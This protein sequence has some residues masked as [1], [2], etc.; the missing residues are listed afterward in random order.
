MTTTTTVPTATHTTDDAGVLLADALSTNA[1]TS[2][3]TG[4]ALALGS[5]WLDGLLGVHAGILAGVGAGLVLFAVGI[6]AALAR[7]AGLDRAARAIIAADIA[8]VAGATV[9]VPL[10]VLTPLGD[11]L[12]VAVSAVVAG[13]AAAQAIGLRRAGSTGRLGV[14]PVEVSGS[15]DIAA[16]PER[17]WAAVAD[18]AGYAAFA[19]GIATTTTDGAVR[20]G[21][22]RRCTDDAGNAWSETCTL[23]EPGRSYRMEVDTETYPLRHRLVLDRFAMTWRVEPIAA[24][25][26]LGLTFSGGAK[27]GVLGRLAMAAMAADAP[28]E[29][30][31]DRYA[32]AL[33]RDAATRGPDDGPHDT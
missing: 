7:P 23:V 2:G 19:P 29:Q 25:S 12:L 32:A 33:E 28:Q 16:P 4:A 6:I 10:D 1:V 24:G 22:R 8:W 3:A 9:V 17:A 15:R 18:A 27:L 26:R 13:F 31:L 14:R 21:M 11:L 20:D 30:I 5:P